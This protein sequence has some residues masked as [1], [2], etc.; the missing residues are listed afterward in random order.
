[1]AYFAA[2]LHMEKPED[3]QKY[4]PQHLNHIAEMEKRGKVFAKG[5]FTEEQGGMII[6]IADSKAEAK[7]MAEKDPYVVH[8]VRSLTLYEWKMETA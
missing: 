1:M 4:R 3:N 7:E 2:I 6:Y 8:G 5:P